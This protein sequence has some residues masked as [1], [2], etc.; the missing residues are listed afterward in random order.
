GRHDFDLHD[1]LED[2]GLRLAEAVL[3]TEDRS[4]AER[5]FVR[6]DVVVRAVEQRD[7]G[8]DHRIT[9]HHAGLD[10][11]LDALLDRRNEFARHAAAND[12]V[13]ELVALA[14]LVRLDLEPHV[15]ELA[16]AAGLLDVFAFAL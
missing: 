12:A 4:H 1:G 9:R 15:P 2:H 14:L 6:V 8:V 5:D 3:E 10:G 13:D 11:F 16:A 7:L